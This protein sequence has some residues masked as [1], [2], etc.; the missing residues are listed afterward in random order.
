MG[1]LHVGD[2]CI[3]KEIQNMR[4]KHTCCVMCCLCDVL[5]MCYVLCFD[6][7]VYE[8]T[9]RSRTNCSSRCLLVYA[10]AVR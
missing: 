9:V 10:Y 1:K 8:Y 4:F 2:F 5:F 3:L 7:C 6:S